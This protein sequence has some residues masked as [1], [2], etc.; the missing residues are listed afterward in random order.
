MDSG[1][2]R[3]LPPGARPA[4]V[5]PR[6]G[7]QLVTTMSLLEMTQHVACRFC[8]IAIMRPFDPSTLIQAGEAITVPVD[9][10]DDDAMHDDN[11][12]QDPRFF[13]ENDSCTSMLLTQP[14]T[15]CSPACWM[16]QSLLNL[17]EES[18]LGAMLLRRYPYLRPPPNGL[19]AQKRASLAAQ[20]VDY[21]SVVA[22]AF[23]PDGQ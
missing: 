21:R 22:E 16:A 11:N 14:L 2:V 8:G 4:L 12:D 6:P 19:Y 1:L 9:D 15:V 20:M 10:G 3:E 23:G 18:V 7:D 17:G 5:G 13:E